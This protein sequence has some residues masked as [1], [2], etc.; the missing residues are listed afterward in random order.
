MKRALLAGVALAALMGSAYAADIPRRVERQVVAPVAMPVAYN[1]TGF[2]VGLNAGWGWGTGSLSGPPASGDLEGSGGLIGGTLGYN[3]QMNQIVFGVETDIAW[4]G[5]ETDSGCGGGL[6]CA[7]SNDWLGTARGRLGLA[8]DRVMPYI[9]G[10]LA[11][12]EVSAAVTGN[13]GASETQAGWTLGAGVEFAMT[14][15]W[16]AKLE[17][18]YV[19]L[20]DFA[21]GT[22]C[23]TAGPDNVEFNAHILRAGLNYRF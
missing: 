15:P 4:S 13:P 16:T 19:D 22:A 1:W 23:G 6:R 17:Y 10:G 9:T 20:G 2:Y 5:I 11:Y 8:M 3:W 18:L 12:G 14:A 7:V 21:C